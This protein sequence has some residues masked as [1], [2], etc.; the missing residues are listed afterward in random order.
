MRR[1]A[2]VS[3]VKTKSIRFNYGEFCGKGMP[4][5]TS[6]FRYLQLGRIVTVTPLRIDRSGSVY[7]SDERWSIFQVNVIFIKPVLHV[8]TSIY[9]SGLMQILI[10]TLQLTFDVV[11]CCQF[12]FETKE[13]AAVGEKH[14]II[15]GGLVFL[16]WIVY[17]FTF[18]YVTCRRGPQFVN[19]LNEIHRMEE[20]MAA[21]FGASVESRTV[22]KI[23]HFGIR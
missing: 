15:V 13:S 8:L 7:T 9:I 14:T 21:E 6:I 5:S 11:I 17:Y 1:K 18:R 4:A 10:V 22:V 16:I 20:K 12:Y 3:E 23:W 19:L 2:Y